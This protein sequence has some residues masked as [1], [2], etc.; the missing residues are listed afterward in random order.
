[1]EDLNLNS[2]RLEYDELGFDT[3]PLIPGK[4]A[5]LAYSWQSRPVHRLWQNVPPN[6]NIGIRGGGL[7]SVAVIDCDQPQTFENIAIWL[8]GLGYQIGDYPIVKTASGEGRHIYTS[9]GGNLAGDWRTLHTD[10]GKGEFRYGTGAVIAA[11][12]SKVNDGTYELISGNFA[13]LPSLALVDVLPILGNQENNATP[14]RPKPSRK[15]MALLHGKGLDAY[16]SRSEAE[17]AL[18]ASLAN[19][20]FEFAD[21][22][23]LF[24]LYPCAGKYQEL[25]A[26]N[27]RKAERWLQHSFGEAAEWVKNHES[28]ARQTVEAAIA[29]AEARAWPGRTG[30][31]DRLIFLAHMQIA[32]QAGRLTWAAACRTLAEQMGVSHMTATR[33]THRLY[34]TGLIEL[35]K[36]AIVDCANL[37]RLGTGLDK[38][39]HSP[40]SPS[41]R[42]CNSLSANHDVFRY[43]GLGKSASEIWQALQ[44]TPATIEELAEITGRQTKT[45][46]RALKR[47]AKLVDPLT[48]EVLPMVTSDDGKTWR[49]LPADLD[50]IAHAI[51]TAGIGQ[52]QKELHAKERQAQQ[53][54]LLQGR[55]HQA[56]QAD[57]KTTQPEKAEFPQ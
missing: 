27:A 33:A 1:M 36:P 25:K 41:V 9:F 56:A 35:D 6:A 45:I 39:L 40:T 30:A 51:G 17:Q 2:V 24:N 46:I 13:N 16:H 49:A 47:M 55:Q 18:L 50:Q 21:V 12:P 14:T 10:I 20:G 48:G 32:Y 57:Q 5:P 28:N 44:G 38:E 37:Y 53:K 26:K 23:D 19:K 42:K 3:L 7:A 54:A 22:L 52:R 11:P 31:V 43:S 34:K 8:A 29:W 4:K 15:A